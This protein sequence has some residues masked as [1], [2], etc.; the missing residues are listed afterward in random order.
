MTENVVDD[1]GADL[2]GG[3]DSTGAF[4][5]AIAA[6]DRRG[7]GLIEIPVGVYRIDGAPLRV[8]TSVH[9]K[10]AGGIVRSFPPTRPLAAL[11]GSMTTLLFPP[12]RDGFVVEQHPQARSA[13]FEDLALV[14]K[15]AS[16]ANA[17]RFARRGI[18]AQTRI[19]VDGVYL[20]NWM[21]GIDLDGRTTHLERPDIDMPFQPPNS[22]IKRVFAE[23]CFWATY[24]HGA[25]AQGCQFENIWTLSCGAGIYDSSEAGNTYVGC[26][27]DGGLSEQGSICGPPYYMDKNQT[28]LVDCHC[29]SGTVPQLG[30]NVLLVGGSIGSGRNLPLHVKARLGVL[31]AAGFRMI[32]GIPATMTGKP[33][34]GAN[35]M[36]SFGAGETI[37]LNVDGVMR[38]IALQGN[39]LTPGDVANRVNA[40]FADLNPDPSL[41]AHNLLPRVATADG[42]D[43]AL[44]LQGWRGGG[45]SFTGSLEL[46]GAANT[47]EKIGF[48]P[49]QEADSGTPQNPCQ[50]VSAP[51]NS[52]YIFRGFTPKIPSSIAS[53]SDYDNTPRIEVQIAPAGNVALQWTAEAPDHDP[54]DFLIVR[55]LV[56]PP[57]GPPDGPKRRRWAFAPSV[58]R[59]VLAFTAGADDELGRDQILSYRGFWLYRANF[60]A[61]LLSNGRPDNTCGRDND[62]AW[63][64]SEKP[65]VH[66]RKSGGAWHTTDG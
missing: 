10:G 36:A 53:Q 52:N 24:A 37:K 39:D 4:V 1:H 19:W 3:S 27:V 26:Y 40:A 8:R 32:N 66:Y 28:V 54:G 56:E 55:E 57:P 46:D 59:N 25:D 33:F 45:G 48:A 18:H 44:T 61:V 2:T 65:I 58:G 20:L 21:R 16:G 29:E 49:N 47:L 42:F 17:A 34:P 9:F 15:R 50:V 38:T 51:Q 13:R 41:A 35:H 62:I 31:Q 11:G 43:N 7:G 23:E 22:H 5:A 30:R 14:R 63:D 12:D 60:P 64:M 6:L